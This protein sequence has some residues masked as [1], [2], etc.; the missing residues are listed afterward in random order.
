M[1]VIVKKIKDMI[2]IVRR[3]LIMASRTGNRRAGLAR[4]AS[5]ERPSNL[6]A[7]A[8]TAGLSDAY[9]KR[10]ARGNLLSPRKY[11]HISADNKARFLLPA[12]CHRRL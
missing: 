1:Q 7:L 8:I 10:M 12:Q 6:R 11:L 3:S 9:A 2:D 5:C 4:S